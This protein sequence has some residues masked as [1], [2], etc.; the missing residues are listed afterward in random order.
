MRWV[1]KTICIFLGLVMITS[2]ALAEIPN[3]TVI[4]GNKSFALKYANDEKNIKEISDVLKKNT[5][6]ILIKGN[7]KW[8]KNNGEIFNELSSLPNII[9]TDEKGNK[10]EY[11][12]ANGDKVTGKISS[13]DV[14][15]GNIIRIKFSQRLDKQWIVN[16]ENFLINGV[17]L[18]EEDVITYNE[19]EG[20]VE[21]KLHKKIEN[22]VNLKMKNITNLYGET[23]YEEFKEKIIVKS[24]SSST[25]G[26]SSYSG[27]NYN[28]G[29]NSNSTV[30]VIN[31]VLNDKELKMELLSEYQLTAEVLP[32]NATNK[33]LTW[34]SS[35][36]SVATVDQN[37]KV[38]AKGV[39]QAIITVEGADGISAICNV[40][41]VNDYIK[42]EV[43]D[44]NFSRCDSFNLVFDKNIFIN[45]FQKVN[46]EVKIND[47][48][49]EQKIFYHSLNNVLYVWFS[50]FD[51]QNIIK[52]GDKIS[53]KYIDDTEEKLIANDKIV[54]PFEFEATCD[55]EFKGIGNA[56]FVVNNEEFNGEIDNEKLQIIIYEDMTPCEIASY[57]SFENGSLGEVV[58]VSDYFEDTIYLSGQDGSR[59]YYDIIRKDMKLEFNMDEYK[60]ENYQDTISIAKEELITNTNNLKYKLTS[61]GECFEL[62]NGDT[63]ILLKSIKEGTGKI[64]IEGQ[65]TRRDGSI[66]KGK[67]LRDELNVVIDFDE[68]ESIILN[69]NEIEIELPGDFQ[70]TAEVLPNNATNKTLTWSSS[71]T[72][73]VTVD[74]N[75][76]VVARGV[77]EA[78]ITVEGADGISAVC[79]VTVV[80][81]YIEVEEIKLNKNEIEIELPGDFQLTAEVLPN[82]ATNKTLTWSSS[83]TSVATVDQNGKVVARGVGQAV[84]SVIANNGKSAKC[85][86]TVVPVPVDSIVLEKERTME[87]G[88]RLQLAAKVYPSNATNKNL[89]WTSSNPNI[90]SVDENG[91]LMA[92]KLGTVIITA[93]SNNSKVATCIVKSMPRSNDIFVN[94][95]NNKAVIKLFNITESEKLVILQITN[96]RNGNLELIQEY[97]LTPDK[98][99]IELELNPGVYLGEINIVNSTRSFKIKTFSVD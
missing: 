37:G 28:S 76:K 12:E 30:E 64:I 24:K 7:N 95:I 51:G 61:E 73:V 42:L 97:E 34:K 35:D 32:N 18:T 14:V 86:V 78:V 85:N 71:D 48:I 65:A 10:C 93:V 5:G 38:I 69:K 58:I 15:N 8:F 3:Y 53:L 49:M 20:Y 80:N 33:T 4:I 98:M 46:F 70:L 57:L 22:S 52:K 82:N 44:I 55:V 43:K 26:G 23:L 41:V 21:I 99:E 79:N 68:A 88:E 45:D 31:I 72:S 59:K 75:G 67:I 91:I 27:G 56:N 77:G 1:K 92:R 11:Q 36:A 83:D 84:I 94:V 2:T 90:I 63:N 6:E 74:Q 81:D 39:G 19:E 89:T 66:I 60:I 40:T 54:L 29:G 96:K 9:H 17:E 47:S 87:L 25:S 16:R 50:K 62:F 13:I